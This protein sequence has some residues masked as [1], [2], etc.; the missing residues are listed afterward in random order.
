[1]TKPVLKLESFALGEWRNSGSD[2]ILK[3]AV[4]GKPIAEFASNPLPYEEMLSYGKERGGAALRAMSFHQRAAMLKALAQYLNE[5]RDALYALSHETG[6]TQSDSMIDID[7]GIST[8]F[9]FS[10][11]GRR[12]LPD[13][14]VLVD[15]QLEQ[16]S[17]SGQFLGHHVYTSLQGVALHINAYNFPVWGM[18][19]KLAP[20]LLAGVPAIVKPASVTSFLTEACFKLM[21]QSGLLPDGAVQLIVGSTGDLLEHLDCQDSVAFTGSATTAN[22]LKAQP[23]ILENAVRFTAEQDSLNGSVL[24]IDAVPDTPEFDAFI[25]EVIREITTKAGQKCTAIRRILVPENNLEAVASAL[26]QKLDGVKIGHPADET[27]RMGALAG[28]DQRADVL[29]NLAA[30]EPETE[31]IFGKDALN[32]EGVDSKSGAFMKPVLLQCGDP[33]A[34]N[35]VHAVE[36]FGPVS[37]LMPYKDVPHAS[38]LLNKGKGSLVASVFTNEPNTAREFVLNSSA[39]HGRLYFADRDTGREATGHGS[40]LPHLVHGGPGRAGGG[41]EMGGIRG[42]KHY[43]QR[44]AI[45]GSPELLSTITGSWIKGTREI[46][47]DNHPF[48]MKFRELEIGHTFTSDPREITLKDIEH[49]AKFTGDTFYAHMDEEAAKANPFFPGRVA[50]GYLLLSFAAGLFVDPDPGPVLANYGLDN[51]RFTKPVSPGDSIRVRLTAKDKNQRN[52]EYGEV[53][54]DVEIKNAEDEPVASY[55]LLTMNEV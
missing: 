49:F 22:M 25:R 4:S 40:P 19:E 38:K 55:E 16:L 33:D 28:L 8:L 14:T 47:K 51:L 31:V 1:M 9:V 18:L 41:E 54:W 3:S 30:L 5:R 36:A 34:A 26:Q 10:S 6:A 27:T 24:G 7:G 17:K 46:K 12:E 2:V 50:H 20:A 43:M 53:R 32:T 13:D 15:G 52:P 11:K 48:R 44:T 35:L 21:V 23:N 37:T 42:V 29:A 39:F 45:Q